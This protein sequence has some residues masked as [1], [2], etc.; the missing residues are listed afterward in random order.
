MR[1][2]AMIRYVLSLL[3]L[4]TLML[5]Q[6]TPTHIGKHQINET[7]QE[8]YEQE[9]QALDSYNEARLKTDIT[10]HRLGETF[11]EWLRLNQLDLSYICG[12]HNRRDNRIDFKGA[13]KKLSTTRDTG[14]GDFYT[15]ND[16]GHTFGWRFANGTVAEY[17]VDEKWQST[18]VA[19][20]QSIKNG[21]DDTLVTNINNRAYTW[22]FADGRLS[23]VTVTPDWNAIY[24]LYS[25]EGIARHPEIVPAFLEEVNLLTQTYGKPSKVEM[26]PY[27]NAYGAH[28]GRSRVMWNTPDGT[29]ITAFERTEF[30]HQGQ[31]ELVSF[32]SK[33]SLKQTEQTKPNPYKQ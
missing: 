30:T 21:K 26:V 12:K 7:V 28:W 15:I 29:Q 16:T 25:E 32:H 13:C 8:W 22:K 33:E 14:I 10:P 20:Q 19:P 11:S 31:L 18:I 17:S 1:V 6:V 5:G 4:A 27:G 23:A 3:A 9:P 24:K 2:L